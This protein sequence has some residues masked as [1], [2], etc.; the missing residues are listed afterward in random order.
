VFLG[1]LHCEL[2]L[3][4]EY[5]GPRGSGLG[6]RNVAGLLQGDREAGVR[7]G[8]LRSQHSQS[9]CCCDGG[10]ELLRVSQRTNQA[11]MRLDV[12]GIDGD[13]ITEGLRCG[14][15]V[16]G[17]EQVNTALRMLV[18]GRWVGFWKCGHIFIVTSS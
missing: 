17:G 7:E 4:F 6:F 13:G 10:F 1:W 14:G 15:S 5:S 9:Q 8:I 18:A 11:V 12:S 3:P 2:L 16:S